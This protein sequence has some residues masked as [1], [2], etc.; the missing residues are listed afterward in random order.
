MLSAKRW[1]FC[2]GLNVFNALTKTVGIP[3]AAAAARYPSGFPQLL[4]I[5][6]IQISFKIMEKSLNLKKNSWNL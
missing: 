3:E 1:P 5:I 6:E 2:L 4:K